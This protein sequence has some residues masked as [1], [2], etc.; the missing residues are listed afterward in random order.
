VS[1]KLPYIRKKITVT[2]WDVAQAAMR[3]L[4]LALAFSNF[5][6]FTLIVLWHVIILSFATNSL[7]SIA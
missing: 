3:K 5:H 2:P 7:R 6:G 4:K 1:D